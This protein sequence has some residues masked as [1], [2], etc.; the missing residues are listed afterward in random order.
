MAQGDDTYYP[1]NDDILGGLKAAVERGET[2]K[3]A[4]MS[5]Y[6]SGYAKQEIEEAARNYLIEKSEGEMVHNVAQSIKNSQ[7]VSSSTSNKLDSP[8]KSESGVSETNSLV[9]RPGL[10]KIDPDSMRRP[11]PLMPLKKSTPAQ[12]VSNYGADKKPKKKIDPITIILILLLVFLVLIL[13]AVF[14]FKEQLIN[15]FNG[16]FG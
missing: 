10:K 1:S 6:N 15:F 3:D 14:M 8:M 12:K 9:T 16:I 5:F 11:K 4:M 2:L 7:T 13:G